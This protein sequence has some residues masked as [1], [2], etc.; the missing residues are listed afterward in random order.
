M[1]SL[2]AAAGAM[3]PPPTPKPT[4]FKRP[5]LALKRDSSY[6]DTDDEA[7]LSASTKKLRVAF[8]P[9]V[10]VRILP[11]WDDKSFDLVKE[12][13]SQG[14]E[15]HLAPEGRRDDTQYFKL[16]R[17]FDTESSSGEAPTSKLLIKYILRHRLQSPLARRMRKACACVARFVMARKI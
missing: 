15:R 8:D 6:L 4:P 9:N 5:T 10:D 1:V 12:E 7:G 3:A 17:L 11:D 16:L 13:V 14:I 2:A